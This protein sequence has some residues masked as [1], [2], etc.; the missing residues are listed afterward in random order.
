MPAS[1][2]TDCVRLGSLASSEYTHS[3]DM[4]YLNE[5]NSENGRYQN[6]R[7]DWRPWSGSGCGLVSPWDLVR[8]Q[9][10]WICTKERFPQVIL[11]IELLIDL[12]SWDWTVWPLC[13]SVDDLCSCLFPVS[14][15]VIPC[16]H[17]NNS[18]L[19]QIKKGVR[20]RLRRGEGE[21]VI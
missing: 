5:I 4:Q 9:E 7:G 21:L 18:D 11:A 1:I 3:S 17:N 13:L 19:G 10:A 12:N 8:F 14:K 16:K 6:N 15:M 20:S 2:G